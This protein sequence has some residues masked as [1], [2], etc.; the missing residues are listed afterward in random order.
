MMRKSPYAQKHPQTDDDYDYNESFFKQNVNLSNYM[1]LPEGWEPVVLFFYLGLL[2]YAAGLLFIYLFIAEGD[3][4]SFL[5]LDLLT[6]IPVWSIG[7]ETLAAL[8]LLNIIY[9]AVNFQVRQKAYRARHHQEEVQKHSY[10]G[11]SP[12]E[13]LEHYKQER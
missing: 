9:S 13:V 11:E 10:L 5:M 1:F 12:D 8:F 7:Y 3:F 2:P 4:E 6:I